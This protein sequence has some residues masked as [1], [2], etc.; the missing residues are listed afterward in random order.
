M[1]SENTGRYRVC[2]YGDVRR[3]TCPSLGRKGSSKVYNAQTARLR[4]EVSPEISPV[5]REEPK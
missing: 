5:V 3:G 4:A 1:F 2:R